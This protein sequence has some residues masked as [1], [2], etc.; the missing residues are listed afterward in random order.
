[1]CDDCDLERLIREN[2]QNIEGFERNG[3]DILLIDRDYEKTVESY[4]LNL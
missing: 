4:E 1:M 2:K 3:S